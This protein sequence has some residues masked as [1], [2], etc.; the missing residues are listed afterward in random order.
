M[1][2]DGLPST[3]SE[4]GNVVMGFVANFIC[5]PAVQKFCKAVK[6]WQSY[7][8]LFFETQCSTFLSILVF[9]FIYVYNFVL[10]CVLFYSV[11]LMS[12]FCVLCIYVFCV[13]FDPAFGCYTAIKV[14]VCVSSATSEIAHNA[15][16]GHSRS[17]KVNRCCANRRRIYDFLLALNSNLT[18][19]FNCSWDITASLHI[20]TP[21]LFQVELEKD[22]WEQVDMLWCQGAQNIGLYNNKVT[23]ALNYTVWSKCTL[24]PDGQTDRRTS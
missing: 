23:L 10:I 21:P 14:C 7:R 20:N 5:F 13:F 8:E 22:D 2:L 15:W 19:I 24:V 3:V 16:N 1:K 11:Y 9:L 4:V 17:L 18:Y 12:L 6:I